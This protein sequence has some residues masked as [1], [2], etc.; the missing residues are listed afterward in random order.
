MFESML[1]GI[2]IILVNF[3]NANTF[4]NPLKIK[5]FEN[6]SKYLQISLRPQIL[7]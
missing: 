2:G 3:L 7:N 4:F 1:D 6:S 5:L